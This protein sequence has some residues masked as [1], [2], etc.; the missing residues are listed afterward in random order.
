MRTQCFPSKRRRAPR[1]KRR[2]AL[3]VEFAVV[4]PI[5]FLLFFGA[6]EVTALNLIRQTA[7]NASYEGARKMIIPGGTAA[8][9]TAEALH[10]MNLVGLG[11]GATV[12][13][14]ETPTSVTVTV[15]VPASALSW[16]LTNYS[17]GVT[18]RQTCTLTKE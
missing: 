13:A 1:L 4:A 8:Q 9:A 12:D 6:I 14:T 5:I 7:G 10:H 3:T 16:G 2:G 15:A 18:L 17:F 11:T